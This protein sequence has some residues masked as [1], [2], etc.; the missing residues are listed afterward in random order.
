ML[1]TPTHTNTSPAFIWMAPAAMCTAL[2]EEPQK[3]FTV[4]PAALSGKSASSEIMRATL[5]SWAFTPVRVM[6]A[7]TTSAASSS[8]RTRARLPFL[9]GAK[10]ERA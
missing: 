9:A 3:R 10:G 1:S 7:R 4:W 5:R 2:I 8:G 6:S